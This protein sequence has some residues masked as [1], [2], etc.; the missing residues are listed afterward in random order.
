MIPRAR[1][2]RSFRRAVTSVTLSSLASHATGKRPSC[3]SSSTIRRSVASRT[4][5][6]A[7]E[8]SVMWFGA[9]RL[10]DFD[11]IACADYRNRLYRD[12]GTMNVR[13]AEANA[14]PIE[15]H[16][17]DY[18]PLRERHGNVRDQFAQRDVVDRVNFNGGG[19]RLRGPDVHGSSV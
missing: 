2:P 14:A 9:V 18:I 3:W 5:R 17:V 15:V 6:S 12:G 16:S 4:C 8:L 11:R 7:W 1:S 19:I 13:A 10:T